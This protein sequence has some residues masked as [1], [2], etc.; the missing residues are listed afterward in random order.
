MSTELSSPVSPRPDAEGRPPSGEVQAGEPGSPR[1]GTGRAWVELRASS[2]RANLARVRRALED[3]G[4]GS[5]EI[6]PMVKADAYGL[7]VEGV[8]RALSGA[9][10][11]GWGVAT[12]DEALALRALGVTEPVQLFS[13]ALPGELARAIRAGVRVSVSDPAT[14]EAL[15]ALD[16]AAPAGF[17]LEIDTGMGRAGVRLP[18]GEPGDPGGPGD[19][20][21][22][23]DRATPGGPGTPGDIEDWARALV[24]RLGRA[25]L[26]W[27]GVFTHLHSADGPADQAERSVRAQVERFGQAREALDRAR[28]ESGLPPLRTHVGNSAGALRFPE[29]MARFHGVRPGIALYGGGVGSG[30]TL[31]DVVAV[32]ARVLRV[33]EVPDGTPVGYGSTYRS[34]GRERWATL[35]IGY[36]DGLPRA[37]SNRGRALLGGEE[38]PIVGRIS[39]DMT[40]VDVSNVAGVDVGSVATLVGSDGAHRIGL[41]AVA[42]LAG[43]IDYEILTGLRP[44]LPRLWIDE[45]GEG[46]A[47]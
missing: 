29:L 19:P 4:G 23:G 1:A 25:P 16:P 47:P 30:E 14:L 34:R 10:V 18:G 13:P 37:L 20:D 2:L 26:P 39:M 43:T 15:P 12:V 41:A 27:I 33:V 6:V 28:A 36:G 42:E 35:G 7:G 38:V 3:A 31:D 45:N 46:E 32:R 8:V 17:D 5:M 40:V 9:G 44:R 22:P 21:N 11:A 24:D